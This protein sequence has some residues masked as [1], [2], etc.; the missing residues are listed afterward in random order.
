[1][2]RKGEPVSAFADLN[3]Y[4]TKFGLVHSDNELA[5]T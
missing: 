4:T 3:Y 1:M 5:Q 2:Q